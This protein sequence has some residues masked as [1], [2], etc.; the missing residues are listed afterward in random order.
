MQKA[1]YTVGHSSHTLNQFIGLLAASSVEMVCDVRS[2]PRSLRNPHFDRDVLRSELR[3]HRIGYVYLGHS[4]GG[5]SSDPNCYRDGRVDYK[6]VASTPLFNEGI[7]RLWNGLQTYSIVLMCAE[8]D[9]LFCHRTIL[10]CRR[11]RSL[12]VPIMHIDAAGGLEKQQDAEMRLLK[13]LGVRSDD[14]F[15]GHEEAVQKAFDVQGARIAYA[16][17]TADDRPSDEFRES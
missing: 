10:V 9:P 3:K 11:L 17:R 6:L 1:L 14:L 13:L 7:R 8:R 4:L 12:D 15:R 5:R 2:V 16:L